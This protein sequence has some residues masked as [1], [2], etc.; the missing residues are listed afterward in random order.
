MAPSEKR[1]WA[2]YSISALFLGIPT[3]I[4]LVLFFKGG[5]NWG[6]VQATVTLNF[7]IFATGAYIAGLGLW[8]VKPW[9]YGFYLGFAA[10]VVGFNIYQFS[11]YQESIDYLNVV[12]C[13]LVVA[14]AGVL[15]SG[16]TTA[17]FF[18]PR[19]RWWERSERTTAR[20]IGTFTFESQTIDKE[21]LDL[22]KTGIFSDLPFALDVG[23]I[24][25]CKVQYEGILFEPSLK[26]IRSTENPKGYGLMYYKMT[27]NQH[28]SVS[29]IFNSLVKK[30][31][32]PKK[33]A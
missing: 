26:M 13:A 33:P 16:D 10:V 19:L 15:L 4:L 8:R 5:A 31:R 12:S 2:I 17:P 22:S 20:I 25:Q 28:R 3:F 24:V 27:W 14:G 29:R 11:M 7:L 18:N 6:A 9:G 32:E 1:P 30:S 23:D 21:I